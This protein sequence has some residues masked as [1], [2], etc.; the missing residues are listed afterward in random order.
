[1]K[2]A[3]L[4]M[5]L[6]MAFLPGSHSQDLEG[7]RVVRKHG[8]FLGLGHLE[9]DDFQDDP[10]NKQ[11]LASSNLPMLQPDKPTGSIHGAWLTHLTSDDFIPGAR[12]LGQSIVDSKTKYE[13][14]LLYTD[15]LTEAGLEILRG[16]NMWELVKVSTLRNPNQDHYL[17]QS[18]LKNVYTKC[19]IYNQTKYDKIVYID[20]DII[21]LENSDE[22]FNCPGYCAVFRNAFFNTGVIVARPSTAFFNDL[23]A[24]FPT[25]PSYNG[26]E[27]GLLNSYF[28]DLD[29]KCPMFHG[30]P[31]TIAEFRRNG[32]RCGRLPAYY[33]GDIGP[34]YL[35]D[36]SWLLPEQ[37]N[38]PK[39]LHFTLG[40]FKPWQWWWYPIFDICWAW[41]EMY[42]RV[43]DVPSNAFEQISYPILFYRALL[44]SVLLF[45]SYVYYAR[46]IRLFDV[47][48]AGAVKLLTRWDPFRYCS[49]SGT[50]DTSLAMS[51]LLLL[52]GVGVG[53]GTFFTAF[54]IATVAMPVVHPGWGTFFLVQYWLL[55]SY[56]S[57]FS[58]HRICFNAGKEVAVSSKQSV[59]DKKES[60]KISARPTVLT[61][62]AAASVSFLVLLSF[63]AVFV[64][65]PSWYTLKSKITT[66]IATLVP[67]LY[68]WLSL[69][70][71]APGQWFCVGAAPGTRL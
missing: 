28:W 63:L 43:A 29:L 5:S 54:Y 71:W 64:L 62:T 4:L 15:G 8:T 11:L 1:M 68:L 65:H 3:I 48:T 57:V 36:A 55:L 26:G 40:T 44:P 37:R 13:M 49:R 33:N 46:V 70:V 6:G 21:L 14:V 19:H 30:D 50:V 10:L 34:Y 45:A 20:S 42:T 31:D 52:C 24:K 16:D 47:Y 56:G 18:R 58:F 23:V 60:P 32:E 51:S 38:S 27:Q 39:I 35:H 25:L 41:Y 2:C 67:V 66:A 17:F 9:H 12:A 53:L 69:W 59:L 22:L 7:T 61:F